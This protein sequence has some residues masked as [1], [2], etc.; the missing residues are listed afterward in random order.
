MATKKQPPV[1]FDPEQMVEMAAAGLTPEDVL[2]LIAAEREHVLQVTRNP[3]T[4]PA[5][6]EFYTLGPEKAS[7][8]GFQSLIRG[9]DCSQW[10]DED[11]KFPG[12]KRG[13][14]RKNSKNR[15]KEGKH[16]KQGSTSKRPLV[17]P[18]VVCGEVERITRDFPDA[19]NV[20]ELVF[21]WLNFEYLETTKAKYFLATYLEL[22]RMAHIFGGAELTREGLQVIAS[23]LS[24]KHRQ[25][26]LASNA[27]DRYQVWAGT[28]NGMGQGQGAIVD[29]ERF[30]VTA[31]YEIDSVKNVFNIPNLRATFVI[32]GRDKKTGREW[33]FTL[34]H[35]KS[36]RGG[37]EATAKVRRKQVENLV[38][39]IGT[40]EP[41]EQLEIVTLTVFNIWQNC[42]HYRTTVFCA[43]CAGFATVRAVRAVLA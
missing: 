9:G 10:E 26:N 22:A 23:E 36:M 41:I 24:N 28:P 27:P 25:G 3:V 32:E 39:Y 14:R 31:F 30:E 5:P 4:Y 42:V 8:M 12:L 16:R 2:G 33:L 40:G 7:Q 37:A 38:G 21:Q 6:E 11:E 34:D 20:E 13:R 35:L 15:E 1:T 29:T 43:Q 18:L 17:D 19:A